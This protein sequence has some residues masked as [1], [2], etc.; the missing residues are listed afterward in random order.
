VG[1]SSATTTT[2][3]G[4]TKNHRGAIAIVASSCSSS[5]EEQNETICRVFKSKV[6]LEI[7]MKIRVVHK[8]TRQKKKR[9]VLFPT[10]TR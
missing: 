6:F 1:V 10:K 2:H 8:Q 4:A 5:R 3:R 9:R 7:K